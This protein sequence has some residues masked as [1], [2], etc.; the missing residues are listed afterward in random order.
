M[1]LWAK[2]ENDFKQALK[3][4]ELVK[5]SVL[6]LLKSAVKNAEIEKKGQG[7]KGELSEEE[8]IKVIKKEIKKREESILNFR[9]G[10]REDLASREEEELEILNDYAPADLADEEIKKII[11]EIIT[12]NQFTEPM[13]FGQLMKLVM[14][15]VGAQADGKKVS[16]LVKAKLNLDSGGD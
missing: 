3:E 6:R 2:I 15:K 5:L 13:N 9:Q 16:Q 1:S 11:D 4:R 8:L 12:A 7:E 14:A 10:K